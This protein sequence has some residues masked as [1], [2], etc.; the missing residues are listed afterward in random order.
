MTAKIV[1]NPGII[2]L[3]QTPPITHITSKPKLD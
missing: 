3:I 1:P 2:H